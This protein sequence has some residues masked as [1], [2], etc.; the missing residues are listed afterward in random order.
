MRICIVAFVVPAHVV[1][2]MP[3][4]TRD[5]ARGLARAGHEVDVITSRHPDGGR[6]EDIVDGVRYVFV[7]APKDK[8]DRAWLRESYAEF[9]RREAERPF[10]VVHSESASAVELFRRG[11]H[12]RLPVV[13]MMHGAL[14]GLAKAQLKSALKTRRPLTLL[15]AIRGVQW[16]A[17]NEHFR[18]GNWYRYRAVETIVPSRQQ[19]KDTRR[20]CLLK[21][22]RVH[23]VPNGIDA[24]LF[25][26][27]PI[28][29]ARASL[30][31]ADGPIFV[32]VGRLSPDKGFH[33]AVQ[34]LALMN[35]EAARAKLIVVGEGPER[36]RLEELSRRVGVDERV[37]FTGAQPHDGVALHLAASDVFLFPTE[38]DEAAPLVLPQAMAC[39]R[40]V[41]ASR[42]G[43]ITEVI[44]ESGDYGVLIPPGDAQA[45]AKEMSRLISD[46]PLRQRLGEAARNRVLA[47]YTIERMVERTL[48]VYRIAMVR[49]ARER[50]GIDSR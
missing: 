8:Y 16:L 34:A 29:D 47:E 2:G 25:R 15:R 32:A 37:I 50:E 10:D 26:P 19:V 38:R 5:L 49:L 43:G 33:N 1:G 44:G 40:P 48:D 24:E 39:G 7:D 14:L 13:V 22:S 21:Q 20:S 46:P 4:H 41:V 30:G 11:V 12:R 31:I 3:D 28:A 23:V 6:R 45:L 36:R 42:T 27:R 17:W 35:G 18:H 9:H